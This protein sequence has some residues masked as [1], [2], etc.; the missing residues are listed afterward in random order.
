M[1]NNT[2]YYY[3]V[4]ALNAAGEGANS[5]QA[6]VSGQTFARRDFPAQ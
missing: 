2:N 5:I 1:A 6:T 4:S 3:V